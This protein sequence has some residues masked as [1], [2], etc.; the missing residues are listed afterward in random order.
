MKPKP[1]RRLELNS[2]LLPVLI[3]VI[4]I[5]HLISPY[6]G[7]QILLIGLGGVLLISYIW[8]KSLSLGLDLD[9]KLEFEWVQVG[10]RIN[11]RF[12]IFNYSWIPALWVEVCDHS[13]IPGYGTDQIKAVKSKDWIQWNNLAIC[14]H[15]GK[16]CLG[17][18]TL[19][20]SDPL[21]LFKV[22]LNYPSSIDLIVLPPILNLPSMDIAPGGRAGEGAMLTNVIEHSV[23]AAS[24]REYV[25]GDS[26]RWI[27][28]PT[29]ARRDHFYVRLFDAT[30][31]S[32]W[33][34]VLDMDRTVH[35]GE[36][37][38][39]TEEYAVVL[40][41]SLANQGL[42]TGQAVGLIS[43]DENLI[44]LPP[45]AGEG[46]RWEILHALASISLSSRPLHDLLAGIAPLVGH[47][48]SLVLITPS[49]NSGWTEEL[50]RLTRQGVISTV[51]LLDPETFGQE[52]DAN[53][54]R[55]VL[56]DQGI[57]HTILTRESL[58]FFE[59]QSKKQLLEEEYSS[60]RERR[61]RTL[62][63]ADIPWEMFR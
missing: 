48:T 15:R 46:Q 23:S 53:V 25:P 60:K 17:P 6:H 27:H 2:W 3:G 14:T 62:R 37:L 21:G 51:L 44:W 5:V 7:W 20:T 49:L 12:R 56:M 26:L 42:R 10:D 57:C 38:D 43:Y 59:H 45:L 8:A 16:F 47:H 1:E 58:I 28:W 39:A 9:R 34:I 41:A 35:F 31:S 50:V 24:V 11:E 29:S 22:T 54:I 4:L 61:D 63:S 30:P 32:D 36:E 18:T 19:H 13:T 55:K 40:A 52:A 33:W